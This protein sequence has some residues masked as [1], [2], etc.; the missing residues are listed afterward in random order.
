M[1]AIP[2]MYHVTRIALSR[3]TCPK[4]SFIATSRRV[5][6]IANRYIIKAIL[7]RA[8]GGYPIRETCLEI[9]GQKQAVLSESRLRTPCGSVARSSRKL[10]LESCGKPAPEVQGNWR[11]KVAGKRRPGVNQTDHRPA[12]LSERPRKRNCN[13]S[14]SEPD[15]VEI[16]YAGRG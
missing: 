11:S 13:R 9:T 5:K 1:A 12:A 10:A 3:S 6:Y 8:I 7:R 14:R 4:K 16:A 15:L 2:T